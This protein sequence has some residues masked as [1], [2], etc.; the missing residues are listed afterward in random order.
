MTV[1]PFTV[2]CLFASIVL[3]LTAC[4]LAWWG[5]DE[6]GENLRLKQQLR[7]AEQRI[8]TYRDWA[9]DAQHRL[10]TYR[11]WADVHAHLAFQP[12]PEDQEQ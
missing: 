6:R 5:W 3:F 2:A 11:Q 8:D 10:S 4:V 7:D 9:E 12:S 1:S